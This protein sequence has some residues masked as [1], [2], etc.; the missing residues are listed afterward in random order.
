[1]SSAP[2]SSPLTAQARTVSRRGLMLVIS[3]PSGAGKTTLSRRL[4]AADPGIAMSVSVTTRKPRPGEVEGRD[5][6]FTDRAGF[7]AL[8]DAGELLEWAEVYS[9]LYG[10]PKAAVTAALEAGRDMLFDVD[11]QGADQLAA[12]MPDDVVRVFILP[13]SA[14]TLRQRL[15]GRAEDPPEVVAHRLAEAA[16]DIAHWRDYD[17]VIVNEHLETALASLMAVLGAERVR[18]GRQV[19]LATFASGLIGSLGPA[20]S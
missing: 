9:N 3:S 18:R 20:G 11:W 1:M 16:N 4:I 5:Y 15:I 17:Y 12:G 2:T 6:F 13:P 19:G 14:Q 10:T 7:T 8:R